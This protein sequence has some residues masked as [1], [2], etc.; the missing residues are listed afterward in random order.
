[1]LATPRD[2]TGALPGTGGWTSP[3]LQLH[4]GAA[5]AVSTG[6]CMLFM[7]SIK[8]LRKEVWRVSFSGV[9]GIGAPMGLYD[10]WAPPGQGINMGGGP[11]EPLKLGSATAAHKY[12]KKEAVRIYKRLAAARALTLP[13]AVSRED[14]SLFAEAGQPD[15]LEVLAGLHVPGNGDEPPAAS[16]AASGQ[17]PPPKSS[18]ALLAAP[19]LPAAGAPQPPVEKAEAAKVGD[20]QQYRQPQQQEQSAAGAA[21]EARPAGAEQQRAESGNA[22]PSQ[23]QAA[24]E[25]V[26]QDPQGIVQVRLFRGSSCTACSLLQLASPGATVFYIDQAA[27]GQVCS[28]RFILRTGRFAAGAVGRGCACRCSHRLASQGGGCAAGALH[29]GGHPGVVRGGLLPAHA[30][31]TRRRRPAGRAL[32]PPQHHAQALAHPPAQ[33][34]RVLWAGERAPSTASNRDQNC[35]CLRLYREIQHEWRR[36]IWRWMDNRTGASGRCNVPSAVHTSHL[37]DGCIW[38]CGVPAGA[39][40]AHPASG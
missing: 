33:P 27:G 36:P 3:C 21:A 8:S 19:S 16:A 35:V 39:G 38:V 11:H 30:A 4:D 14:A 9:G 10:K 18:S 32:P 13:P 37:W 22:A 29:K 23:Q 40:G 24:D 34:P 15:V 7:G 1:M 12:E 25:W 2:V 5:Y 31:H 26:Y 17:L 28:S 6:L 20:E